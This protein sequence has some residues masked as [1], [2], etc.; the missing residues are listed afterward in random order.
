MNHFM[1]YCDCTDYI[2]MASAPLISFA[3]VR[4]VVIQSCLP[5]AKKSDRWR[6]LR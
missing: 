3:E 5:Y 1:Q 6:Q 4:S 2:L